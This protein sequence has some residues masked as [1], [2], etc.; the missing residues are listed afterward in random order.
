MKGLG[1]SGL[2]FPSGAG[3]LKS[4]TRGRDDTSVKETFPGVVIL[5]GRVPSPRRQTSGSGVD[6]YVA[7]KNGYVYIV[8]VI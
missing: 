5:S 3:S 7:H 6:D 4:Y 2:L 8:W 1:G